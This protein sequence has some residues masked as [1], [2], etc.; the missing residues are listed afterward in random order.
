MELDM[1]KWERN[2]GNF[3]AYS[4]ALTIGDEV[5]PREFSERYLLSHPEIVQKRSRNEMRLRE[6]KKIIKQA[7]ENR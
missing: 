6:V 2:I 1:E 3:L 7:Y 4:L 5:A